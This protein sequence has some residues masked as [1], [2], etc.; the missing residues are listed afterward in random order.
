[1]SGNVLL[2]FPTTAVTQMRLLYHCQ[3]QLRGSAHLSVVVEPW[4][5]ASVLKARKISGRTLCFFVAWEAVVQKGGGV[6]MVLERGGRKTAERESG[7][8]RESIIAKTLG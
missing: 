4:A 3:Q 8:E 6:V 5:P 7:R 2:T 1:M